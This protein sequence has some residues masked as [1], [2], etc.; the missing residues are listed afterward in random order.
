MGSSTVSVTNLLVNIL[1]SLLSAGV[2]LW[3]TAGIQTCI[4]DQ[5]R[6]KRAQ[7]REKRDEEYHLE[8]MKEYR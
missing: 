3:I 2:L 4:N 1:L 5:K 8:R 7:E 6:E